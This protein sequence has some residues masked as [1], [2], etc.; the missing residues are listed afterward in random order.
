MITARLRNSALDVARS[1]LRAEVET[2]L[3]EWESDET[4]LDHRSGLRIAAAQLREVT[5]AGAALFPYVPHPTSETL[6][7]AQLL[8][9]AERDL[10]RALSKNADLEALVRDLVRDRETA[11][12][13]NDGADR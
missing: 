5:D 2:L 9:R 6:P 8:E 12:S 10:E 13:K 1:I 11:R 3:R 7:A 4:H